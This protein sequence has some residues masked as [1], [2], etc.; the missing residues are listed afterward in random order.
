MVGRSALIRSCG[1]SSHITVLCGMRTTA[2]AAVVLRLH[3]LLLLLPSV[4]ER[5]GGARERRTS[6]GARE[7]EP[8]E[9]LLPGRAAPS[10]G[11]RYCLPL[12]PS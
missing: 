4:A 9:L 8:A 11:C 10:I 12:R 5:G 1:H 7:G 3:A 6:R 2:A